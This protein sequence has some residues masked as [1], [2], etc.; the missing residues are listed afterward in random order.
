M[1]TLDEIPEEAGY[2]PEGNGWRAPEFVSIDR[3]TMTV[4]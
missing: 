2:E 4:K 1:A 3:L